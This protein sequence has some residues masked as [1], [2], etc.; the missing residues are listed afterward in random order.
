MIC[1]NELITQKCN[2][3]EVLEP[4]AVLLAPFAV[5][6]SEELW[7]LL[8]HDTSI[9]RVP[10]PDFDASLLVESVKNY[11]ISFNGKMRFTMELSLEL[12]PKE[13]EEIVMADERTQQQLQGRTPKKII[14]VPGKIINIVG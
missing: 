5:H 6:A 13:V 9:S 7:Q 11:P 3:R 4:L 1:V 10:F 12:N 14:V 2:E 8:G